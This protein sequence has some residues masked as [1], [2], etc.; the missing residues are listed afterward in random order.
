MERSVDAIRSYAV[1]EYIAPARRRGE[2]HVRIVA[3]EVHRGLNLK[4][5]VPNV[6][7]ALTS[8]IFLD[9]NHLAIEGVSGPPSGMGTRM[10]YTYRLLDEKGLQGDKTG[11]P[12]FEQLRGLLKDALRSL[13]GGEA[14]LREE[15]NGFY[16]KSS[17]EEK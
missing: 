10:T 3:G 1:T 13:G 6:C 5:R 12:N 4:N 2:K 11:I 17:G 16:G 14:F 7:N 15:R 8:R 9:Q